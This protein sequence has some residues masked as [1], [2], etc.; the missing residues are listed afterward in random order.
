[1]TDHPP[2]RHDFRGTGIQHSGPGNFHAGNVTIH[3]RRD[4]C[5][6]DLRTTDPRHDKKRIEEAKGGILRDSYCWI[7]GHDSFLRWRD[8]TDCHLLWIKGDPGKGKTMLLCGI[9]DEM[10][11]QF[12]NKTYVLSFFFCQATDKRLN[13]AIGV[14]RGLIY[15]LIDQERS[16]LVS[17]VKDKYEHAGKSL[18]EDAN[19][20]FA[21]SEMF[22]NI[23]QD[24]RLP[25]IILVVDAL[26]EC[27]TD[28]Y[29]LLDLIMKTPPRSHVK[30]LLSSRNIPDIEL[31]LQPDQSQERLSLELKSN[32]DQVSCAVNTYIDNRILEIPGIQNDPA[33]RT[34]V[35]D[36]IRRKADNTFLWVGLVIQELK[37][38]SHFEIKDI[39]DEVPFGLLELYGRM[40]RQ[41]QNLKRKKRA[42]CFQ[43]LSTVV[44]TYR[45]LCLEELVAFSDLPEGPL[46]ME[47]VKDIVKLCGSFIAIQEG[48]VF[49]IHQSAQDFLRQNSKDAIFPD[50]VE[51]VHYNIFSRSLQIMSRTLQ[52]N[53]YNLR[54]WG[55]PPDLIEPPKPDPLTAVRYPCIYWFDHL[56]ESQSQRELH[57]N[58]LQDNGILDVFLRSHFLHWLEALSILE[59][60]PKGTSAMIMLCDLLQNTTSQLRKFVKDATRFIRYHKPTI[61]SSPLQVYGSALV[62]SPSQ[63]II[64]RHFQ[65]EEPRW[66]ALKPAVDSHWGAYTASFSL[67]GPVDSVVFSPDGKRLVVGVYLNASIRDVAAGESVATFGN[68][69]ILS[70]AFSPNGQQLVTGTTSGEVIVW[71]IATGERKKFRD[72]DDVVHSAK[73]YLVISVT[74]SADGRRLAA[75]FQDGTIKVWDIA[76][77]Q[78][79]TVR[80]AQ[81][82]NY[83]NVSITFSSAG[84]WLASISNDQRIEIWDME[85]GECTAV[86]D[87]DYE[88]ASVALSPDGGQLASSSTDGIINIWDTESMTCLSTVEASSSD[89]C[90]SIAF[91]PDGRWLA[92]GFYAATIHIWDIK[93]SD[94]LLTIKDHN[95]RVTSVAFSPDGSQLASG[96]YDCTSKIWDLEIIET[97]IAPQ[98]AKGL[99][100]S[101]TCGAISSDGTYVAFGSNDGCIMVWDVATDSCL[102]TFKDSNEPIT[103]IAFSPDKTYVAAGSG[104]A[105]ISLWG[106]ATGSCLSTLKVSSEPITPIYSSFNKDY[107][108]VVLGY[109]RYSL[110]DMLVR[111][112]LY[113]DI[114]FD[115]DAG[116]INAIAISPDE[117]CVAAGING[118]QNI[119][120]DVA[121]SSHLKTL[122]GHDGLATAMAFSPDNS[123]LVIYRCTRDVNL[124]EVWDAVTYR[125]IEIFST[126]TPFKKIVFSPDGRLVIPDEKT[127]SDITTDLVV[128]ELTDKLPEGLELNREWLSWNGQMLL[129]LPSEYQ[130]FRT[131]GGYKTIV[132]DVSQT[133][134]AV[135]CNH[136]RGW[137]LKLRTDSDGQLCEG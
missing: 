47:D 7:L 98:K 84:R 112:N 133:T 8:D 43:I 94:L 46:R 33:L 70:L 56:A 73:Y 32:A 50:S 20:W 58:D 102:R 88:V 16:L 131:E 19:A 65:H 59:H 39:I 2:Q 91:S 42:Y 116:Q 29:K 76:T 44:T 114:D 12:A 63:S 117:A 4:Q 78:C 61:K 130:P 35:C 136:G 118:G 1:M 80:A 5:I 123:R 69:L 55:I 18:F 100:M 129:W 95:A 36:E 86:Q 120:W 51:Y 97:S 124:Y 10:K 135:C 41:I 119:I 99:S 3:S 30:W 82:Y 37:Q 21:L 52:R 103:A 137:M 53:I 49:I 134:I 111:S 89:R 15:L 64:R 45:P 104:Y 121:T 83:G 22:T 92:A 6:A 54:D 60:I 128:P 115:P 105:S 85:T 72:G 107:A 9:I 101:V 40:I 34:A 26:D 71:D 122:Q 24:P 90:L 28:L 66:L 106:V 14:L 67:T 17:H 113:G 87:F 96:S 126:S 93:T 31:K 68:S 81:H 48:V 11:D 125:P 75:G 109:A 38:A 57:I 23:I 79:T 77:H 127:R 108:P 62:F 27:E 25:N 13:N 110:W 132:T 74:F